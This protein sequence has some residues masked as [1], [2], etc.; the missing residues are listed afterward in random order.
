MVPASRG[1]QLTREAPSR[2]SEQ[3][4]ADAFAI[5]ESTELKVAEFGAVVICVDCLLR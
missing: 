5:A 1:K 4:D 3:P 2:P